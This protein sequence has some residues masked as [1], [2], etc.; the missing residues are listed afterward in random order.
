MGRRL[1][2]GLYSPYFGSTVGG[3]EKYL[4]VTAEA[5]RDAYPE[6]V[7]EIVGPVPADRERYRAMLNVNLEGIGLRSTNQRV[8]RVHRVANRLRWL[9]PLRNLAV[10]AQAER[11]TSGY[12]LLLGMVYAIPVR[13]RARRSVMLCQFPY[14]GPDPRDIEPYE[15]IISQSQYCREWVAEYWK[16]DAAVINPPIDLPGDPPDWTG[17][18]NVI[19]GVGRFFATGHKKHQD[20]LVKSFRRLCDGGLEGWQLHLA[21]TVHREGPHAGYYERVAALAEGYP[22][23]LHPDAGYQEVQDLYR[24]ATLFWHAAGYGADP[25]ADPAALEH[26]GMTTAEAM[27]AGAVPLAYALGGQAEV[28]RSGVDGHLWTTPAELETRTLE[29]VGDHAL[30]RRMGEAAAAGSRRFGRQEFRRQMLELLGPIVQELS[31]TRV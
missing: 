29:L 5:L 14:P 1:R 15:L 25:R 27:A 26:F 11:A 31:E 24:L 17:K 6:H 19:L 8:T 28:I 21:G 9:R 3:G 18:E 20:L 30:R 13:S 16:R 2:I 7:I 4:A 22:V 23:I 12:D 10:S